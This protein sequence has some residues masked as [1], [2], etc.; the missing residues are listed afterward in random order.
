MRLLE[1]KKM[2]SIM[3]LEILF[4]VIIGMVLALIS[5]WLLLPFLS[6]LGVSSMPD[7]SDVMVTLIT[8]FIVLMLL[9]NKYMSKNLKVDRS[10]KQ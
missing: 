4:F 7:I 6:Y 10:A 8:A 2:F 3:L 1:R 5:Q 9:M